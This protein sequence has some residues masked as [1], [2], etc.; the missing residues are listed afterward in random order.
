[1]LRKSHCGSMLWSGWPGYFWLISFDVNLAVLL[2]NACKLDKDL[3]VT[4][5][6]LILHDFII[7]AILI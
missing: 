7:V 1:M 2:S 6:T 4:L 3:F 5:Y